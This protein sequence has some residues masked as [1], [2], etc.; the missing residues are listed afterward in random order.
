V[1]IPSAAARAASDSSRAAEADG[2]GAV[3]DDDRDAPL[4]LRHLKH[5]LEVGRVP[6]DVE[7]LERDVPPG[8]VLTGGF[9]V[10][11]SV[12]A[13][14]EHWHVNDLTVTVPASQPEAGISA[15]SE[16]RRGRRWGWGPSAIRNM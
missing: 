15:P 3:L 14:D 5:P 7:I 12:F 10:G 6:L 4:A 9:R 2:H 1:R 11:S 16:A 13:E 8:V